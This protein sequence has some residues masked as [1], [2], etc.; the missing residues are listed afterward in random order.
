MHQA[1]CVECD[2][3]VGQVAQHRIEALLLNE[4]L[5]PAAADGQGVF[6]CPANRIGI[7][8]QHPLGAILLCQVHDR[9]GADNHPKA[10]VHQLADLLSCF[11]EA[12][13][14]GLA[15]V[16]GEQRRHGFQFRMGVLET[17]NSHFGCPGPGQIKRADQVILA[18]ADRQDRGR[19]VLTKIVGGGTGADDGI[20][21]FAVF[22]LPRC[23]E[24]LRKGGFDNL[25]SCPAA[26]LR[27]DLFDNP[28][29]AAGASDGFS[30]VV[31]ATI[32]GR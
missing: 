30:C 28:R 13:I 3:S 14:G 4:R 17:E 26:V 16:D 8:C 29:H 31:S 7:E 32:R 10:F 21:V 23:G 6:Q 19:E 15:D 12:G 1:S 25:D 5:G 11:L 18:H 22:Q 20:Y 24:Q 2:H 27:Y 9:R